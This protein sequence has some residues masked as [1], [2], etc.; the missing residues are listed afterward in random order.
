MPMASLE[1]SVLRIALFETEDTLFRLQNEA[2]QK[3]PQYL[4]TLAQLRRLWGLLKHT[5]SP[6]A[7]LPKVKP[8]Q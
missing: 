1:L 6:T 2:A 7:F 5:H 3:S 8:A 4:Q